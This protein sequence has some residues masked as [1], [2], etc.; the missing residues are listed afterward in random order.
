MTTKE[1]E[2]RTMALKLAGV[3]VGVFGPIVATLLAFNVVGV[4]GPALTYTLYASIFIAVLV[5][6]LMAGAVVRPGTPGPKPDP[7]FEAA[8]RKRFLME[9]GRI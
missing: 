6:N 3:S 5:G 1:A 4:S 8:I 7:A 9:E 2:R